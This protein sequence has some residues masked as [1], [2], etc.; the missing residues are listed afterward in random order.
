MFFLNDIITM[1]KVMFFMTVK[2]HINIAHLV[3][4]LF[5]NQLFMYMN[6]YTCE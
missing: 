2:N 6:D 1:Y 5:G 4:D 3:F